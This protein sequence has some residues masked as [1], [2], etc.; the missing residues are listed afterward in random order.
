M[1]GINHAIGGSE[2]VTKSFQRESSIMGKR[3]HEV[4]RGAASVCRPVNGSSGLARGFLS[5]PQIWP[6]V[7]AFAFR[8]HSFLF[9][10]QHIE[11]QA[12]RAKDAN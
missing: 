1:K 2:G 5:A 11:K 10:I 7:S 12:P 6:V 9:Y 4:R 8:I 3:Q